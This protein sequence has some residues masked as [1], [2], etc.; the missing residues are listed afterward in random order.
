MNKAVIGR[1][2][3]AAGWLSRTKG[4]LGTTEEW[5]AGNRVLVIAPCKSIHTF[6]MHYAI[7]VAFADA[8]GMVIRTQRAVKPGRMLYAKGAYCVLERP[9]LPDTDWFPC[10]Q[11]VGLAVAE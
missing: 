10:H 2:V 8:K 11:H 7:D 4:L 9:S 6:G 3:L 1:F 5:G